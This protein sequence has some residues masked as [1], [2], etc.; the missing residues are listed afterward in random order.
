[1][2]SSL[3]IRK[4]EFTKSVIA[5]KNIA[6]MRLRLPDFR[7][8]LPLV[9]SECG[10]E[11][12]I[13]HEK[14]EKADFNFNAEEFRKLETYL[15]SERI[16]NH[17][18]HSIYFPAAYTGKVAKS[19]A[20]AG[21]AILATDISDLWVQHLRSLG[22]RTE[23]KSFEQIPNEKFD[24]VVSFEPLAVPDALTYLG[25]LRTLQR[26]IPYI[27]LHSIERPQDEK[28]S[29]PESLLDS[30][31]RDEGIF[32]PHYDRCDVLAYRIILH[33]GVKYSPLRFYSDEAYL[34]DAITF[35]PTKSATERATLDLLLIDKMTSV[36]DSSNDKLMLSVSIK[37]IAKQLEKSA[38]EIAAS[39]SRL[40]KIF[41]TTLFE[42]FDLRRDIPKYLPPIK[43]LE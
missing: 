23:K 13:P 20:N 5:P 31:Y 22:L 8:S 14:Q 12:P 1:M 32:A 40:Y 9:H 29:K 43:I 25:L 21:Y 39:L 10:W 28:L 27:G 19:L 15:A 37:D 41:N 7:S 26:N 11:N 34:F 30:L 24:A 6:N 3:I 18:L 33:Y 36:A 4:G 2:S 38:S 35:A 17:K 42:I 16:I